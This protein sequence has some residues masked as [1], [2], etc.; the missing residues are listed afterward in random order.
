MTDLKT[1]RVSDFKA[2]RFDAVRLTRENFYAVGQFASAD[3]CWELTA[4]SPRLH[5]E[6]P[7]DVIRCL[8]GDWVLKSESGHVFFLTNDEY[9]RIFGE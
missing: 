7:G 5:I 6:T 9:Q 8:L 3:N 4:P 2:H 1:Q